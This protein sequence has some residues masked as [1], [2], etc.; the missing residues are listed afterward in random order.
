MLGFWP[1][2]TA[3][4]V[5]ASDDLERV[6]DASTPRPA[7]SP[8]NS[9]QF[10]LQLLA[11]AL[12]YDEEYGAL[13]NVSLIDQESVREK[14]LASYDPERELFLIE[15]A[16]EWED[17]DADDDGEVDY[18][19]AVDGKEFKT[20]ETPEETA[21]ALMGLAKEHNLAPSFMILFEEDAA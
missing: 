14:F 21:E 7:M 6:L 16:V 19:L 13:G 10:A 5:S 3:A 12:F 11:E 2:F 18:A 17:L 15:E 8:F 20:F 9:D 4:P 1:A